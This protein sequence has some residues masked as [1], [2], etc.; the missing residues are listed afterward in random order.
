MEKEKNKSMWKRIIII[1]GICT[2]VT[3]CILLYSRFISTKGLEIKEYKIVNEKITH[4]FHGLKIVHISDVHYG[5]TIDKNDLEKIVEK[6]NLLKPDI[7]VLTGDLLDQNTEF[8]KSY[9]KEITETLSKIETTIGKYAITGNHDYKFKNF[10]TIIEKSGFTNL[11][12]TYDQIYKNGNNFILLSGIS[13]NMHGDKKLEEKIESTTNLLNDIPE[14]ERKNIY[15]ILLIHEPDVIDNINIDYDLILAGHSHN[16]QVRLPFIGAIKKV[17]LAKKYYEEYYTINN[18][19]LYISGGLGTST[20]KFRFF[21]KPSIN[22]Y[23]I[24]NK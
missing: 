11:N 9:E 17:E 10:N 20:V 7:V 15:K 1:L 4:N 3:C 21:N 16:G 8:K 2:L 12:D 14:E 24:T 6:I 5:T 22:F 13:T 23:R 19:E 18:K